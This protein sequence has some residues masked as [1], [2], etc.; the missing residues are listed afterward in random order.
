MKIFIDN[1]FFSVYIVY[2][3]Y[4]QSRSKYGTFKS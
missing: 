4:T 1:S 2:I 3:E